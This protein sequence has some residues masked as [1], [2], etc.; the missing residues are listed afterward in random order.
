MLAPAT[1]VMRHD[2]AMLRR[3]QEEAEM[4]Q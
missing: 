4:V 2:I 1:Y 3:V